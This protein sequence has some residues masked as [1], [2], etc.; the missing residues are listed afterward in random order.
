[1]INPGSTSTKAAVF[2]N[3]D[4]VVSSIIRHA[5]EDF[6]GAASLIDQ[7]KARMRL[8]EEMLEKNGIKQKEFDAVVG[9]G[10]L[11]KP[12]PSGTYAVGPKMLED[13]STGFA[14]NH[15]SS[16]GGIIA[17][18]IGTSFQIPAFVVDPVV[19][20]ELQPVARISGIPEAPR[21]SIFH[22]LNAKA[23]ARR[24]AQKLGDEYEK[25]NF[26][27]SHMGGGIS[28]GAHRHGMVIDVN[29][30]LYGEGPFSPERCGGITFEKV[31]RMCFSREYTEK[32]MMA[33]ALKN[34]G[35]KAYIGTNDLMAAE[36]KIK[37]GDERAALV[38]EAM[39][40][41]TAKEIGAMA[42]VLHYNVDSILLTGGLAKSTSFT[43]SIKS[44]VGKIAPV[45]VYP[46]E[47][48]MLALAL[49]ALR[50]LK[51]EDSAA[52]YS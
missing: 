3:D 5:P 20:D 1:V 19:V 7:K 47:D 40:Y 12:I 2:R 25:F 15:A 29:D 50:V 33:F 17:Y 10:G 36:E 49:G 31:V 39:A 37:G 42:A 44:M 24:H 43:D 4:L 38:V 41:Q 13:L 9:R 8:I 14:S 21:R 18:E 26:V 30:A 32:E 28:V 6:A 51:G 34:G 52:V 16:L 35:M 46:G 11:L 48:E 27:V 22:A 45:A 23:V